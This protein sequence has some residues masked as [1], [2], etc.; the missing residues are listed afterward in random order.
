MDALR[1]VARGK[2]NRQIAEALSYS[3]GNAKLLVRAVLAKLGVNTREEAARRAIEI[4][5]IPPP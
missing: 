2:T 1:L 4:G 5:L 3:F